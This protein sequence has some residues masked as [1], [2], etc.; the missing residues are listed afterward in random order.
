MQ[1]KQL[2]LLFFIL[3]F[4]PTLSADFLLKAGANYSWFAT[5]GGTS[6][7]MPAY[8]FGV[9]FPLDDS[10][11]VKFGIDVIYVG[12]KMILKDK[13]WLEDTMPDVECE[14]TLGDLYLHYHYLKLPVYL[15]AAVY[16]TQNISANFDVGLCINLTLAS[17]S[18]GDNYRFEEDY[19]DYDYQRV[20]FE[21]QPKYPCEFIFSTGIAC[22]TIGLNLLYSY[23][24]GKTEFLNGLTIQDHIHSFR[25]MLIW[26][27]IR[28]M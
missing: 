22:K 18:Y 20:S 11:L 14:A 21:R 5:E 9:Q 8:G 12:Q 24:L 13:S 17:S 23:T 4:K 27:V 15:S 19:C 6:E 28:P 1:K 7:T 10:R 2:I 25:M 16:Q 26:Y 3:A